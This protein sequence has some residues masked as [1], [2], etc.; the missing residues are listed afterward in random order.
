MKKQSRTRMSL[1]TRCGCLAAALVASGTAQAQVLVP[2][3]QPPKSPLDSNV[4]FNNISVTPRDDKTAVIQFD[5][6]WTGS[7][8]TDVNHDAAWI[9]FK[10]RIEGDETRTWRHVRLAADKVLNPTGYGQAAGANPV[11]FTWGCSSKD[12]KKFDAAGDT[13][14]DFL[15]PD[16]AD[17][18]AGAFVRRADHGMGTASG[19]K[20]TV[21]WDLTASPDVKKDTNL[22]IKAYGLKMIYVAEGPFD[23]G[24]GGNETGAFYAFQPEKQR[25][26]ERER[27]S[28]GGAT[29]VIHEAADQSND[30][31][32]YRVTSSNAIPT[33]KTPGR[34]WARAAEPPEGGEIPATFPNGYRA[35]YIMHRP[36]PQAVYACFLSSLPPDLAEYHHESGNHGTDSGWAGWIGKVNDDAE[37]PYQFHHGRL[38]SQCTWWLKWDDG[39]A[40]AAWAGLRPM[41][42]LENEKALRG[43]R[44]AAPEECGSSFWGGSYGG[45]RYNAH[46]RELEVTV[47]TANGL[48][49][50]GTHGTGSL[51]DIPGDW[52]KKDAKGTGIRNGQEGACG[53]TELKGPMWCTSCRLEANLND[54]ERGK[55]YGFRAA[56]TAPEQAKWNSVRNEE[57]SSPVLQG[58]P[59]VR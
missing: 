38:K 45:A 6:G 33:G 12:H 22:S 30:F 2:V 9:F 40:F 52:P 19:A 7:W 11:S 50:K 3:Q 26:A 59:A 28:V 27:V 13:Q 31:P 5:I 53:I 48:A 17:G 49:F 46:P 51:T 56:R 41:T 1:V 4:Y 8:R 24:S 16:G 42:E 23:L 43:P 10:Y 29:M 25:G 57:E 55:I 32:P 37:N 20:C 47:A 15:V 39:I 35:F 21:L 18:F 58:L 36:I 34:L 14:F 54:P 44:R